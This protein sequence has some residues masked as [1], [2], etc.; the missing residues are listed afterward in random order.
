LA[1]LETNSAQIRASLQALTNQLQAV[2]TNL[3]KFQTSPDP[4]KNSGSDNLETNDSRWANLETN[5]AQIDASLQAL[6]NQLQS[7]QASLSG[8]Q[9]R[10]ESPPSQ[11]LPS[12]WGS[13]LALLVVG[14]GMVFYLR[15][16]TFGVGRGLNDVLER[17]SE[18]LASLI[19]DHL[20]SHRAQ[21]TEHIKTLKGNLDGTVAK[22]EKHL[23]DLQDKTTEK[24]D[25]LN[26]RI[27]TAQKEI[28]STMQIYARKLTGERLE[29]ELNRATELWKERF[30]HTLIQERDLGESCLKELR[31]RADGA[32]RKL[33]SQ[34]Q[35]KAQVAI[36]ELADRLQRQVQESLR[37]GL[38]PLRPG[39][40]ARSQSVT[41][42]DEAFSN[43]FWPPFFQTGPLAPW[44]ERI[45]ERGIQRDSAA[46]ALV[47][48]LGRY[49]TAS[50]NSGELRQVAEAI[51]AVSLNAY[52][53]W[54]HNGTKVLE[55]SEEWKSAFQSAL[56][57]SHTPL[58]IILVLEGERFDENCMLAANSGSANR[59]IVRDVFSWIVRDKSGPTPR[60]LCHGRVTTG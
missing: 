48:A 55:A 2:Q 40:E 50:R 44:R 25:Q 15:S 14:L 20:P 59:I 30:N 51:H 18:W 28:D 17:K 13:S 33:L 4:A 47:L 49:N 52:Q 16:H 6:T 42:R 29:A 32:F 9:A 45:I 12:F 35:N 39:P 24:L 22:H 23:R 10:A 27:G 26:L 36:G 3:S 43:L 54:R 34:E 41:Q 56:D 46:I 37:A 38:E 7:I 53:F 60:V 8:L 31:D 1:N 58:D 5:S 19:R 11:V 21:M 57:E